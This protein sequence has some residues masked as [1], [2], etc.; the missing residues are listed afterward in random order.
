[1]KILQ[2]IPQFILPATDGGKIGIFNIIKEFS[3]YSNI[4]LIIFTNHLP[5][6]E[7]INELKEYANI[8]FIVEDI[9]NSS[10]NIIKSILHNKSVYLDKFYNQKILNQID[11][12]IENIEF[13][14]IHAD[15]TSMAQI[16][17]Y[18]AKKKNKKFG[19]RLHN[20]EYMIWE[21]YAKD[22]PI[23][24]PKKIIIKYQSGLLKKEEARLISESAISFPITNKDKSIANELSPN[25][26]MIVASAGVDAAKLKRSKVERNPYQLVIA[27]TYNWV[28]NVNGLIWFIENVLSKVKE[29][30]P[31][32]SLKLF[33][34]NLPDS[35]KKYGHLGVEAIGFVD[36]IGIE[37]SKASIYISP[38]FVGSGIRIKVLEALAYELPVISTS[39]SAEGIEI[40]EENGLFI[41]DDVE[42]QA[43]KIIALINN[44][45]LINTIGERARNA[46]L[47][48]YTWESN[49][50]LM[51][52]EYQKIIND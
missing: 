20:I 44:P 15:H 31:N 37:L 8:H 10:N 12:I 25:S 47:E 11:K 34:K 38:L 51:I 27:T 7:Y 2:L 14:I 5:E 21:R 32:I 45:Q 17:E 29:K 49:V 36:D 35:L 4:E 6:E 13:D 43:S 33:G 19:L 18:I 1:M 26:K 39:I 22:L 9:S 28:H 23:F 40:H 16:A 41:S 46:V 50:K 48:K 24:D 3:K 42:T 30:I 52:D